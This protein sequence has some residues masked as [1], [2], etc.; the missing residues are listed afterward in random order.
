MEAE[1]GVNK[2]V[3]ARPAGS[4]PLGSTSVNAASKTSAGLPTS[5]AGTE[6]K[7]ER[8]RASAARS[9]GPAQVLHQRPKRCPQTNGT[10]VPSGLWLLITSPIQVEVIDGSVRV[11]DE[12]FSDMNLHASS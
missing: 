6:D 7:R 3:D 8:R 2:H 11:E 12:A 9:D 5:A 1:D 10:A 4:P